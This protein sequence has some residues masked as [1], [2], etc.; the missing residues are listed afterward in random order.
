MGMG[1]LGE[2]HDQYIRVLLEKGITGLFMFFWLIYSILKISYKGFK[3]KDD[4]FKKSLCAGLFVSTVAMLVMAI[5][6]DVFMVVKVDEVYWF[7]AA[8][9]MASIFSPWKSSE[10]TLNKS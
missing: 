4:L 7:F 3:E 10:I 6:N 5:P 2:A 9:T 8:M 1:V